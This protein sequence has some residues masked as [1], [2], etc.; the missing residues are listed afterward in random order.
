MFVAGDEVRR[1]QQGNNNTYCQDNELNWFDWTLPEANRD[2]FRFWQQMIAFRKQHPNVHRSRFFTGEV[3]ERNL[4]DITW[5]G[6]RLYSPGWNDPNA[7]VLAYTLGGFGG[8]ADL[9]VMMNMY[10]EPLPFEL[11]AAG[12]RKWFRAVDTSLDSPNDIAARGQE[13]EIAGGEYVVNGHGVV[14]VISK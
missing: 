10:W 14:V 7:R 8:E 6:C 2:L 5:H 9:H 11:P 4:A 3:N 12:G 1:T 13:V